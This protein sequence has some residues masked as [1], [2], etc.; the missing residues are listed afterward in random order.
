MRLFTHLSISAKLIGG[1]LVVSLFVAVAGFVGYQATATMAH[2][3][4]TMYERQ[5]VPLVYLFRLTEAY[6]RT[7]VYALN[8]ILIHDSAEV[9]KMKEAVNKQMYLTFDT[10]TARYQSFVDGTKESQQYQTFR[11]SVAFFKQTFSQVME[12]GER[13]LQD[14]AIWYYRFGPGAPASR[15]MYIALNALTK[16]KLQAAEDAKKASIDRFNTLRLQLAAFTVMA[17]VVAVGLGWWLARS[18]GKPVQY[19]DHAAKSVADGN[20]AV[21]VRATTGDELGSL[22]RSFNVMVQNIRKGLSDLQAEKASVEEK[23]R[24]AVA[25]SEAEKRYLQRSVAEALKAMEA[26][27]A[28]ALDIRLTSQQEDEISNLYKGFNDVVA[29][30]RDLVSQLTTAIQTSADASIHI[31]EYA[32][33]IA[34]ATQEQQAQMIS[35]D[36]MVHQNTEVLSFNNTL[37]A[38]AASDARQAGE[39]AVESGAVVRS[40]IDEM[41]RINEIVTR[42]G[43]TIDVLKSNSETINDIVKV[44]REIADQTNLLALNASIEAARAG[45]QGR[46]FAVV[47]DEV[48]KLAER[49]AEA[50][51]EVTETVRRIQANTHTAAQD[52][53]AAV[54]Q[55]E[56]GRE[57]ALKADEA[58]H[59]ILSQTENVAKRITAVSEANEQQVSVSQQIA[60]SVGE[61]S[62]I[63]R[64]TARDTVH[65]AQLAENLRHISERLQSMVHHFRF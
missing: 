54:A 16:A 44:I 34:T 35:I 20:V 61:M 42:L 53:T 21:S 60:H 52:M 46:G 17:L 33:N 6:Q 57:L 59:R 49:T 51:K 28:G 50:T 24:Q 29:T 19:L 1:F 43:E 3:A 39:T 27:N 36:E 13:G 63:S 30:T 31:A 26:F 7:R 65:I 25:A 10:A 38:K 22:A 15:G 5:F 47:A 14:S 58:L 11:D 55:V 40:T 4:E 8:F 64:Q 62:S 12:L 56:R 48:R 23:V 45:E 41:N 2:N 37:A 32:G 9:K 18:I